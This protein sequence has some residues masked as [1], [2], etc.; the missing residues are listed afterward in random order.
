MGGAVKAVGKAVGIEKTPVQMAADALQ[1]EKPVQKAGQD[2]MEL[3]AR[4]RGARRRGA[5]LM[6]DA[7]LNQANE[8]LGGSQ[9]L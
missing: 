8:T 2:E 7:T 6:S 3:A 5:M 1:K 4:R 9:N